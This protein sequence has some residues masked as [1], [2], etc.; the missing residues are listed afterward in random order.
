MKAIQRS[1]AIL[2]VSQLAIIPSSGKQSVSKMIDAP[3][4]PF[5]SCFKAIFAPHSSL[6]ILG[7]LLCRSVKILAPNL[8]AYLLPFSSSCPIAYPL[9]YGLESTVTIIG[10]LRA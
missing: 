9:A 8:A 5:L 7:Y 2:G 1:I 6:L 4:K 10:R 3:I